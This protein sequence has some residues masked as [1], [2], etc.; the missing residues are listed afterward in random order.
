MRQFLYKTLIVIVGIVLVYE[1]TIGKQ[2]AQFKERTNIL[3]SKEGRRDG[4]DKL[5]NEIQKAVNKDRYLSKKD[6]ILLNKFISKIKG[7]LKEAQNQN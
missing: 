7:E 3:I 6:A 4:V 1:F 2:I 5:R